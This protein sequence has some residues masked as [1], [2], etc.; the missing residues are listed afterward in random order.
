M[1]RVG[2]AVDIA[3]MGKEMTCRRMRG[4]PKPRAF[5]FSLYSCSFVSIRGSPSAWLRAMAIEASGAIQGQA[6]DRCRVGKFT[7]SRFGTGTA[8]VH[9]FPEYG[10]A[11]CKYY[12]AAPMGC[13]TMWSG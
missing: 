8:T 6:G 9:S 13:S 10:D 5:V 7:A 11:L 4:R 2:G 3:A 1:V 12:H